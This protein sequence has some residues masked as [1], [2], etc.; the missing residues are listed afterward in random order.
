METKHLQSFTGKL[1][2]RAIGRARDSRSPTGVYIDIEASNQDISAPSS[3]IKVRGQG[4]SKKSQPNKEEELDVANILSSMTSD[5][6]VVDPAGKAASGCDGGWLE[7]SLKGA[8]VSGE[9]SS[10]P[11]L[12]C[13]RQRIEEENRMYSQEPPSELNPAAAATAILPNS[14]L[15]L[16]MLGSF[17]PLIAGSRGSLP[18]IS[19]FLTAPLATNT[20][21]NQY[22]CD[23]VSA[24][25]DDAD[26]ENY[27]KMELS[28]RERSG[29]EQGA[30]LGACKVDISNKEEIMADPGQQGGT[31]KKRRYPTSRPFKCD[32]CDHAFN[33]RV[34]LR[35]H[36][37]KH[38]GNHGDTTKG[39]TVMKRKLESKH[40]GNHGHRPHIHSIHPQIFIKH[41]LKY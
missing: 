2:K 9:C 17:V 21:G 8:A 36:E 10:S 23:N 41:H 7:G 28:Q 12:E 3:T 37:S 1:K 31:G 22:P 34:H 32:K 40:T 14:S 15:Q 13:C 4:H 35:K 24:A 26:C 33:Q 29:T 16:Q 6:P 19:T 39:F 30:M 20:H 5:K 25:A 27:M 11:M 38:T 18:L